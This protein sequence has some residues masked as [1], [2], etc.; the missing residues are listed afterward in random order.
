MAS[1]ALTAM[2]PKGWDGLLGWAAPSH[3]AHVAVTSKL[4][5][6]VKFPASNLEPFPRNPSSP[7]K[8]V[9]TP[10]GQKTVK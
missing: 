5:R 9:R 8:T 7:A 6:C 10:R 2:S 1:E 4:A 3:V